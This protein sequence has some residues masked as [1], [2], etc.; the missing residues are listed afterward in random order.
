MIVPME[1][2]EKEELLRRVEV[3]VHREVAPVL[4]ILMEYLD[5]RFDE[6]DER[7]LFVFGGINQLIERLSEA[8]ESNDLAE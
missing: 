3:I 8:L 5:I 4:D 1:Q 2:S 6:M 7:F